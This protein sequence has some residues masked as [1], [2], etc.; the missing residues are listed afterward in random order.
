MYEDIIGTGKILSS[1]DYSV[2]TQRLSGSRD[3]ENIVLQE[4]LSVKVSG[5]I[6]ELRITN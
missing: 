6:L 1:K 3:K 5:K 2:E 4:K